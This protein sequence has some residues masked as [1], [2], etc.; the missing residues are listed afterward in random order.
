MKIKLRFL[1]AAQ[2]VTGSRYLLEVNGSRILV[3][4]GLYQE[5]KFVERN[6]DPFP[7]PPDSIETVLLTHGHLDHCGFVPKLVHD[8]FRGK[9]F[10]TDATSEIVKIVLLNGKAEKVAIL[11]FRSTLRTMQKNH[12]RFSLLWITKSRFRWPTA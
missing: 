4:C 11:K 1:G 7:V 8:G 6:W 3:D 10:C 9:I 2:N 5:R 12:F